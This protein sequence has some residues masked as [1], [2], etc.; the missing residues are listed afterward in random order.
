MEAKNM[1]KT[2]YLQKVYANVEARNPGEKEFLQTVQEVLESIDGVLVMTVNPGFAGQKLVAGAMNK[3]ARVR[4]FLDENGK[5]D[6][7]IEVDGNV[8]YENGKLMNEAGAD[9]FVCGTSSI[10]ASNLT[11]GIRKFRK[12]F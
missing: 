11:E 7:P 4:K 10:F 5:N 8:S 3:I 1:L 12:I 2:A 6:L 9:I